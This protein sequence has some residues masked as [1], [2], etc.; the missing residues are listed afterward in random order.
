MS[1]DLFAGIPREAV[2]A[3]LGSQMRAISEEA[4]CSGWDYRAPDG[5][6]RA[7]R[8]ISESGKP[9]DFLGAPISVALARWLVAM[10]EHLGHWVDS[11]AKGW[12]PYVPESERK[13]RSG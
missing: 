1:T 7:C 10:A 3:E 12:Q 4:A 2:M 6:P 11:D 13:K 8:A 5:L 9:G